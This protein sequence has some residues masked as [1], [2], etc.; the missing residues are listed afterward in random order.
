M[1]VISFTRVER[2][3]GELGPCLQYSLTS[4][5][6]LRVLRSPIPDLVRARAEIGSSRL[7]F[8]LRLR[9][10]LRP[11]KKVAILAAAVG[12]M[13]CSGSQVSSAAP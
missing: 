11:L 8:F 9:L 4:S 1:S 5:C 3:P 12:W 7:H 6:S 10:P 2:A 13:W